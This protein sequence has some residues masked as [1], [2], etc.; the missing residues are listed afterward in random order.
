[1][2]PRKLVGST[3]VDEANALVDSFAQVLAGCGKTPETG[4]DQGV[5]SV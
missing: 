5:L 4:Y 2:S 1:M 3:L